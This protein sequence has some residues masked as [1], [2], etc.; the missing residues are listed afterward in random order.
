M[1]SFSRHFSFRIVSG[2]LITIYPPCLLPAPQPPHKRAVTRNGVHTVVA[3][4]DRTAGGFP[5]KHFPLP[6]FPFH[7]ASSAYR[8]TPC[9]Y[10]PVTPTA[11]HSVHLPQRGWGGVSKG[12]QLTGGCPPREISPISSRGGGEDRMPRAIEP[13][14]KKLSR[15]YISPAQKTSLLNCGVLGFFLMLF[16]LLLSL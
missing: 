10:D 7:P 15:L 9:G 5:Q 4:T 1:Q 3:V 16:V 6:P 8:C 14:A 11:T 2:V 13:F 12:T